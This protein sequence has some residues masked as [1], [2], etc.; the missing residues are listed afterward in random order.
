[1]TEPTSVVS[2]MTLVM[3][4]V[5]IS[6][7]AHVM[8]AMDVLGQV[9]SFY[10]SAWTKLVCVIGVF[11]FIWP[12]IVSYFQNKS[13][14]KTEENIILKIKEQQEENKKYSD[15]LEKIEIDFKNK[16]KEIDDKTKEIDV[17]TKEIDDK[18]KEIDVK[19]KEIDVKTKEI[20]VKAKKIEKQLIK[21]RALIWH[22]ECFN[23]KESDPDQ[24]IS[25]GFVSILAYKIL[26]DDD[27]I[28]RVTNI[29]TD[30]LSKKPNLS[31]KTLND[32]EKIIKALKDMGTE[33][34]QIKDNISNIQ[35]FY[36][37]QQKTKQI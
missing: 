16:T 9:H 33:I 35:S 28:E 12:L 14:D 31:P 21:I 13:I 36:D 32:L 27:G 15:K 37:E 2:T 25:S 10:D 11:G 5:D 29:I 19:T 17:K 8:N 30:V 18:T 6:S 7:T 1:M 34:Q 24:S 22:M 23:K 26:C 20:D 4:S 3:Q